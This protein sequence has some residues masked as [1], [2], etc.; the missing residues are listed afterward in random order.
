[1]KDK[2]E[3]EIKHIRL[4][5]T[6]KCE[7][8]CIYCDKEG[9]IPKNNELSVN[10]IIKLTRLL[11]EVLEVSRIKLTGGEP[12][13]REE[14]VEIVQ[15]IKDLGL[16]DDI[17]MTT[18]GYLLLEKAEALHNAGLDRINVSLPSLNRES[19]KKI[20]GSDGLNRVIQGIKKATQVGLIPIKINYVVLKGINDTELENM[21]E[22]SAKNNVVLQL[23]ELHARSDA[24]GKQKEFYE[25]YHVDLEEKIYELEDRAFDVKVRG[26][27]QNRKVIF[28]PNGA[29]IEA[30]HPGHDFCMGCTKLR[31]GCDGNVF[32]CLYRADSGKNVKDDLQGECSVA[33]FRNA[34]KHVVHSREPYY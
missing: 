17:S 23:I 10:E 16:Y 9:F 34:I 1:M 15:G 4:S 21:I 18:N 24:V 30:I 20:T 26:T 5:V 7:Y 19:Y 29:I 28:L 11:A 14:I 12:L 2:C 31:V 8:N 25:R 33:Q 6:E 3:R 22:F 13:C 32:G 27:M